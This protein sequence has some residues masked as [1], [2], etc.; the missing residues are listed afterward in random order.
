MRNFLWSALLLPFAIC[1]NCSLA[2]SPAHLVHVQVYN[3]Q[4]PWPILSLLKKR[5]GLGD[6]L[7][8]VFIMVGLVQECHI[9]IYLQYFD[10]QATHASTESTDTKD[11]NLQPI[12]PTCKQTFVMNMQFLKAG[13]LLVI[14]DE[15]FSQCS[16]STLC[17]LLRFSQGLINR[18]RGTSTAAQ[19]PDYY[20]LP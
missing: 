13:A 6:F 12:Y 8:Y 5:K 1:T 20:H 4:M 19:Q 2:P 11:N 18:T 7:H 10:V 14:K 3:S 17:A 16:P 15:I 9:P